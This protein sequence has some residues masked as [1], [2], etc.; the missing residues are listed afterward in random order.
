M[1]NI[2]WGT[3]DVTRTISSG[4]VKD[5]IKNNFT[6]VLKGHIAVATCNLKKILMVI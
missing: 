3:T 1:V 5:T 6:R 4:K 2:K